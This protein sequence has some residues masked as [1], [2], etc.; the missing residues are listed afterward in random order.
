MRR[1]SVKKVLLIPDSFKGTMSS[2]EICS[3]MDRQIRRFYPEAEILSIPVADGGEGS[4]DAFLSAV[5][6]EKKFVTVKGPYFEEMQAFYGLIDGGN[7][8]VIEM[9]ACAGL[10]LVGDQKDPLK[11]TTYG[12]GQLI[13]DAVSHGCKTVILGLGGSATNDAGAG[14]ASAL[15]VRFYNQNGE[16]FV[17]VGGTLCEVDRIDLSQRL[18]ALN[19]V[20][21]VTMCDIDNPFYGENGAAYIF[22]PQKG[23]DEKTV[24]Q[25]DNGLRHIAKVIHSDLGISIDE[26]PGSGA[27]GGMGGGTV[28]FFD[29]R[30]QMGI[31]TV[32]DA[33]HFDE[34]LQGA[35]MVFSGEGKIDTQS[36]RGKVVIGVAERTRRAGVPLIA[37]VGDI[38]DHIEA[39]YDK[40]VNAIFSINRVA[41][42][43]KIARKRS[44]SDLELTMENIMRFLKTVQ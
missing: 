15:G 13:A 11:T 25:L 26:I 2:S 22:G 23:A 44:K 34:L 8:A 21:F 10:P 39:A 35:D 41:V 5:G 33:V 36:I 6:G 17:P 29:A 38:G 24:E 12:V 18:P 16:S 14:A 9:A 31:Q 7:T 27:A 42:D 40:G 3:I 4:V 43:F 30:L 32:L 1:I 19:G 28:A 37:V 20:S